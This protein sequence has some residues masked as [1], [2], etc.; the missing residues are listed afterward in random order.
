[1]TCCNKGLKRSRLYS[2]SFGVLWLVGHFFQPQAS[3]VAYAQPQHSDVECTPSNVEYD[4]QQ[5]DYYQLLGLTRPSSSSSDS[6]TPVD[7]KTI[8]K[9]YRKQAQLWH[10]DKQLTWKNSTATIEESTARFA[11]IAQAYEVLSDDWKRRE[12]DLFLQYC[13]SIL[14]EEEA[15][16]RLLKRKSWAK[17]FSNIVDPFRVF[18]EFFFGKE[19]EQEEEEDSWFFDMPPRNA[20]PVRITKH[21]DQFMD[22]IRHYEVVRISQTEEYAPDGT[23]RFYYRIV[24][25]DFVKQVDPYTGRIS[26][27][28]LTRPYLRDEGYKTP[29]PVKE[30]LPRQSLLFPGDV[31]TPKSA[32]LV[33]PNRRYYAGLSPECVLIIMAD[34]PVGDDVVVWSSDSQYT[35]STDSYRQQN[36]PEYCFATLR[37]PHLVVALGRPEMPHRILW[38]SDA[39]EPDESEP[40]SGDASYYTSPSTFL[41]QLDNDGSLVVYKVWSSSPHLKELP[42]AARAWLVARHYMDGA[43]R[44]DHYES[45]LSSVSPSY[46][47]SEAATYKRCMY[48]TGPSGCYRLARRLYQL[49]LDI[50]FR[51]KTIV[52]K[53]DDM[54]DVWMD[55]IMEE[56]NYLQALKQSTSGIGSQIVNKS[57]RLVRRVLELIL[58]RLEK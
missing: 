33:S 1:M 25:Q 17:L 42:L 24:S 39:S 52:A 3:F 4:W 45:L 22:P 27:Q 21:Q 38:Y 12:Y 56:D 2:F 37:G 20:D 53:M 54:F 35:S 49:S 34:N 29:K 51:I 58:L 7:S 10:P 48:A 50:Y 13:E 30:E 36:Q 55:L 6:K 32:L 9:A 40:S 41:A 11:Q 23:G 44:D 14:Q 46:L 57:A 19:T 15:A 31:L 5:W 47:S 8:R 16:A 28:P 26:L 18:E 43:T